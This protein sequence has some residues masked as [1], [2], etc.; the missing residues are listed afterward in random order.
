[1]E[2]NNILIVEDDCIIANDTKQMLMSLGYN[3]IGIESTGKGAIK[4]VE[5]IIPDLILMDIKLKGEL[6]GVQSAEQIVKQL[7]VPV[8]YLTALS[9]EK[10]LERAKITEPFGYLFKPFVQRE[11]F[12]TIEIALCRY[13]LEEK[14]RKSEEKYRKLFEDS[15]DVIY[16]TDLDGKIVDINQSGLELFGFKKD[17][18]TKLNVYITYTDPDDRIKFQKDIT[19]NGYVKN[20]KTKLIKN[21]GAKIDCLITASLRKDHKQRIIGYHGFMRDITEKNLLEKNSEELLEQIIL[22]NENIEKLNFELD[23][24]N[25]DLEL[26]I[27]EHRNYMEDTN[28]Q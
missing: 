24:M 28:G 27:I 7:D 10:T 3:V 8:I 11:L 17:E 18:I 14:L 4:K 22:E 2:K 12:S 15:M 5:E 6:D 20:F 1:M 23:Q 16:S 9:N 19:K 26:K 13:R 25:V 21:D